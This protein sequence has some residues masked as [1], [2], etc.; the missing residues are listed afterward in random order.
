MK[1]NN[2]K[3]PEQFPLIFFSSV[4]QRNRTTNTFFGCGVGRSLDVSDGNGWSSSA[5]DEEERA[6]FAGSE[7]TIESK[8][9]KRLPNAILRNGLVLDTKNSVK[10]NR[11]KITQCG[12]QSYVL[13]RMY[14][15]HT[16]FA[17]PLYFT[18]Q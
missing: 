3:T 1:T 13:S 2:K 6:H 9:S 12:G 16:Y 8:T 7:R 14:Q 18:A 10:T 17:Q 5:S 4:K 11:F 15:N